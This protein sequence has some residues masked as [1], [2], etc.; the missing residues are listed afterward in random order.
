M[1][2]IVHGLST[3]RFVSIVFTLLASSTKLFLAVDVFVRD[4][5]VV[6]V[7]RRLWG[8]DM[9]TVFMVCDMHMFLGGCIDTVEQI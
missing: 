5:V 4:R 7:V 1:A 2:S 8:G 3:Q 9:G 6:V